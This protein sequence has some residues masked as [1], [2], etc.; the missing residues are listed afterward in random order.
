M[1][2]KLLSLPRT[3]KTFCAFKKISLRGLPGGAVVKFTR[4][5]LVAQGSPVQILGA[6]RCTAYQAMLWQASHI[7]SRG[8]WAWVLAQGQSSSAK[9]GGLAVGISSGVIFLKKKKKY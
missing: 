3:L 9:R 6:Y 4:S 8:R 1:N 2:K 7:E 5:A